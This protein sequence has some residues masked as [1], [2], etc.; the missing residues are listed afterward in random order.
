V[1]LGLIVEGHGEV[2]ALPVL[3]RRLALVFAPHVHLDIPAPIRLPKGRMR[4]SPELARA[5]ELVARKTNP[6]GAILVLL[7]ADDDCPAQL[8]AELLAC[9]RTARA[10]RAISVVVATREYE[11]WLIAGASGLR[12]YRGL[13]SDLSPVPSVETLRDAKGWLDSRMEYGYHEAVDQA[14]LS[15]RFDLEA[16]QQTKSFCK[17]RRD[18]M[19]IVGGSIDESIPG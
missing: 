16:A 9:A 4:K 12:G 7:D 8:A 19:R 1:R 14:R 6:D 15:E 3:L 17:L 5:V 18:L 11:S 10:D 2:S 13:A